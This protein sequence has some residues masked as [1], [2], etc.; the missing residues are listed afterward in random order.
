MSE[1]VQQ[2]ARDSAQKTAAIC[3]LP[4]TS[5]PAPPAPAS[6]SAPL[7][8]TLSETLSIP[9][10]PSF[11]I[12]HL[13]SAIHVPARPPPR[14]PHP[15]L[16]CRKLNRKLCR[17][18]PSHPSQSAICHSGPLPNTPYTYRTSTYT[19]G[20]SPCSALRSPR[21][22]KLLKKLLARPPITRFYPPALHSVHA[23]TCLRQFLNLRFPDF[24]FSRVMRHIRPA[25]PHTFP[26]T[27]KA[28]SPTKRHR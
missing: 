24:C 18:H 21:N 6:P 8:E 25:P 26:L 11:P 19:F 9:S 12:S 14:R 16:L 15:L 3:H 2:M 27:K 17:P 23:L 7:S 5:R 1:E 13:P 28:K 4:F 22:G 20:P 10:L